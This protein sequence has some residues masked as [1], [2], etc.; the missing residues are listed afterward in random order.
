MQALKVDLGNIQT[1]QVPRGGY[2]DINH[3]VS[4]NG[5]SPLYVMNSYQDM[6]KDLHQNIYGDDNYEPSQTVKDTEAKIYEKFGYF[7]K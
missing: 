4:Y 1:Y 3:T 2:E 6:V 7:E 5:Y